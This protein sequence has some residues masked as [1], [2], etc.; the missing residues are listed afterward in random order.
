M[1]DRTE[2]MKNH[3]GEGYTGVRPEIVEVFSDIFQFTG[4]L[5]PQTT[6]K[7]I[8]RWDSLQH[9]ALIAAMED[10]FAI[11]L[12]MDEMMEITSVADIERVLDRRGV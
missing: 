10:T 3:A 11:S 9:V 12:S 1:H 7:D 2:E 4:E 8:G 5:S 6:S